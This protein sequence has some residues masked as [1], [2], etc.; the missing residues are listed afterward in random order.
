[1]GGMPL[2]KKIKNDEFYKLL[3]NPKKATGKEEAVRN[4]NFHTKDMVV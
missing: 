3:K 4:F 2:D 1:L